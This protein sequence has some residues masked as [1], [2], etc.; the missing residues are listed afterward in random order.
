MTTTDKELLDRIKKLER[1]LCRQ[2][3]FFSSFEN[4]PEQGCDNTIYIDE[5]TGAMYIWDGDSYLLY[6]GSGAQGTQGIQGIQGPLGL[7]GIGGSTPNLRYGSFYSLTDQSVSTTEILPFLYEETDFANGVLIKDNDTTG[8]SLIEI[9]N[10][11]IYNIQ[12]SAQLHR[13]SGGSSADVII[14]L[15]K[16]GNDI[17]STSTI[18]HF[19]N[20]NVY[21]V[22][23]WNFFVNVTAG[24]R[25]EIMWTQ[26]DG[27]IEL[28]HDPEDLSIPRPA[29]PSIILTVNQVGYV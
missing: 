14:W 16:N 29:I 27:G 11:G 15:R 12:F 25:Y 18:V 9:A 8:Y 26:T 5:S 21:L 4:F 3:Q 17:P 6:P 20:N 7:Q 10:A 28:L 2:V 19:A 13:V 24:D 1:K 22:A 23:A